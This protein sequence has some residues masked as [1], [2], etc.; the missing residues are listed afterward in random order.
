[1]YVVEAK[2]EIVCERIRDKKVRGRKVFDQ[3]VVGEEEEKRREGAALLDTSKDV[4]PG[5]RTRPEKGGDHNLVD[6]RL[7][8]VDKPLRELRFPNNRKD[9][10]VVNR[11]KGLGSVKKEDEALL[12]VDNGLVEPKVEVINVICA[13]NARKEPL[14]SRVD[15]VLNGLHD[16]TRHHPG[17]DPIIRVSN[18]EGPRVAHEVGVLFGYEKEE[19]EVKTL[20]GK[21]AF[22]KG[23]ES[24][25]ENRGS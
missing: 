9:P 16:R 3:R 10:C 20:R 8:K 24:A 12:T 4:D 18:G 19:A 6:S 17:Q 25:E 15:E 21:V 14:L 5:V 2:S 13:L 7:D 22:H 11:V 1:M 23:G